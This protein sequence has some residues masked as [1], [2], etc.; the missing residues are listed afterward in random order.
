MELQTVS[1]LSI[2]GTIFS[3]IVSIGFPIVLLIIGNK[4]FHAKVS[5][6]FIGAA[7]FLV[8]AFFLEQL[9]H[10]LVIIKL[11]LNPTSNEWLYYIYAAAAAAVF[12]ETGR[13]VAM[14][15]FMKKR[16]DFPN[17]FM[18]GIG[19]GG[20]EAIAIGGIGCISNLINMIL[21]NNGVMQASLD[22]LS[23]DLQATTL[24]QISVLWTTPSSHFFAA[25]IERF[26]AVILHI[27]LSLIIY[28]GLKSN[29]K[30]VIAIAYA[31]HFIIDF[32]AVSCASRLPIWAIELIVFIMAVATF[33]LS[34]KLNKATEATE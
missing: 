24:A 20:I 16:F 14:K 4:K 33:A 15:L 13:I 9:L 10:T 28:Q 17:A 25:G 22:V 30:A 32:F 7:T 18:Y 26:S 31:I 2:I 5:T 19:H 11:G 29:K 12:E 21:I 3:M 8:F 1:T 6:F 34:H 23:E 27:G